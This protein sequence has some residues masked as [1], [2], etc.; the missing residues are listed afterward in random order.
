MVYAKIVPD[1]I[2]SFIG[3][4]FVRIYNKISKYQLMCLVTK[5]FISIYLSD[6]PT[7]SLAFFWV[8]EDLLLNIRSLK[9][10]KIR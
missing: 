2:D 7:F 1:K 3:A 8:S 9:T 4:I 10:T 5:I 6:Y